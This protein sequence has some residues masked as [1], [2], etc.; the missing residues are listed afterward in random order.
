MSAPTRTRPVVYSR[1]S[2][3]SR[4]TSDQIR[5]LFAVGH[6]VTYP[7]D[8]TIVSQGRTPPPVLLLRSGF[9]KAVRRALR[10]SHPAIVDVYGPGD[11]LGAE[12]LYANMYAH[13]DFVTTQDATAYLASQRQFAEHLNRNPAVLRQ[14]MVTFAHRVRQRE[15]ALAYSRHEV[16]ERLIAFL[17]RQ[18]VFYGIRTEVGDLI[19]MGL[20]RCDIGAAIGASEASVDEALRRLREDGYIRTGY[21][22]IWITRRLSEELSTELKPEAL[23]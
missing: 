14:L 8:H 1:G 15:A 7:A 13:T 2:F 17:N 3:L 9:V 4:L 19:D 12:A 20:N 5:D 22:K 18:Q 11:V 10:S 16:R 21:K 23:G 6:L